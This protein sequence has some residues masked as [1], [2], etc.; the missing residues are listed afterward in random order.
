MIKI[1]L[2]GLKAFI[3][4]NKDNLFVRQTSEFNGMTDSVETCD[5]SS[6]VMVNPDKIDFGNKYTLGINGLWLV[7]NSRDRI[8]L[9]KEKNIVVIQNCCGSCELLAK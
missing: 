3:R 5:N 2:A 7:G 9:C 6:F 8:Q 1:T 4:K